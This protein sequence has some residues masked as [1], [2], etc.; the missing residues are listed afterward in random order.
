[1]VEPLTR[2]LKAGEKLTFTLTAPSVDERAR[3]NIRVHV[4]CSG[5][6]YVS[7]GDRIS[8]QSYP[9]LTQGASD[10][11]DVEVIELD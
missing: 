6:G 11:V 2:P 9:V 8:T 5:S 10:H 4:D 7:S 3:Y 1:V